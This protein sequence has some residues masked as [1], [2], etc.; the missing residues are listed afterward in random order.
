M[1]TS[2]SDMPACSGLMY[3]GVP[4]NW[5]S[6]VKDVFSVSAEIGVV[7]ADAVEIGVAVLRRL[8]LEGD[9]ENLLHVLWVARHHGWSPG[10][11][12]YY[13]MRRL[14]PKTAKN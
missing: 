4:R 13:A 5:P 7:A 12:L 14:W 8:L 2:R 9:A 3:W 11:S 1:S 6:L 10:R